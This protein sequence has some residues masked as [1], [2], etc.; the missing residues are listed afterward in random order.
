MMLLSLPPVGVTPKISHFLGLCCYTTKRCRDIKKLRPAAA[1]GG[2]WL[3]PDEGSPS[4]AFLGYCDMD[5]NGGGWT[6]VWAYTF[7]NFAIFYKGTNAMTPWP[8]MPN[9][10]PPKNTTYFNAMEFSLWGAIGS[11]FLVT[12]NINHWIQ[13]SPATAAL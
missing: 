6:L 1:S 3:D 5:T 8:T 13:C 10:S 7:T 9:T 12:S 11:D 2:H 4:N